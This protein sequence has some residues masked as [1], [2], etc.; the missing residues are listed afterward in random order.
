M[1][2]LGC[3]RINACARTR[4]HTHTDTHTHTHTHTHT[5]AHAHTHVHTHTHT[6]T[7]H[8]DD[9]LTWIIA[10]SLA[11]S[12]MASM[13]PACFFICRR[14]QRSIPLAL[15]SAVRISYSI[16]IRTM[17][18]FW[19]G[20]ERQITTAAQPAPRCARSCPHFWLSNSPLFGLTICHFCLNNLPF[21]PQQIASPGSTICHFRLKNLPVLAKLSATSTSI[22]C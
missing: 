16:I 9:R 8:M 5:Y 7:T 14:Y 20:D 12:P 4:A 15:P 18:A 21:Q 1:P 17:P 6:H 22:T 10:T 19:L 3:G 2:P 11:P 13:R